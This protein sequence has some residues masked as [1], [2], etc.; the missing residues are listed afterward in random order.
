MPTLPMPAAEVTVDVGL[1]CQ[2]VR[3][4][5]PQWAE[6]PV[7]PVMETA[8]GWDNSLFRLGDDLVARL[9]RRQLSADLVAKEQRWLPVL[10]PA[11]SLPVPSPLGHGAPGH[12]Y[13]WGWSVC[14][15]LPGEMA[16]TAVERVD[17][18]D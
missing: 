6:L 10:A 15:W 9:P 4:Q 1:V 8:V 12:G 5:F 13:P 17:D 2:L 18:W 14:P 3:S 16:F 11:L 7:H